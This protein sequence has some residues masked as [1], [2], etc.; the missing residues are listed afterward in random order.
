MR[1]LITLEKS[2]VGLGMTEEELARVRKQT[3]RRGRPVGKPEATPDVAARVLA[4]RE[5]GLGYAEIARAL[6]AD[7]VPTARGG[8]QWWPSSVRSL[9]AT[10]DARAS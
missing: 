4:M 1:G 3:P 10:L 9:C 6:N 5:A 2:M 8:R 7:V